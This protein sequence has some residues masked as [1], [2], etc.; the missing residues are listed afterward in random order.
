M[1]TQTESMSLATFAGGCFWCLESDFEK[2]E[3]VVKVT[4]GYTGGREKNP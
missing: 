2:V 1:K 4:S 3:G